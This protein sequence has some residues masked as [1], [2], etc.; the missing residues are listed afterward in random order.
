M[1]TSIPHRKI[2]PG[3]RSSERPNQLI[4]TSWI[5]MGMASPRTTKQQE[6]KMKIKP[7]KTN[8]ILAAFITVVAL[9]IT[10][11]TAYASGENLG[12]AYISSVTG[13]NGECAV[14]TPTGQGDKWD[15]QA[16]GTYT[17]TISGA[18]DCDLGQ[19][20]QI[21]VIVH[22][23]IGGNIY[24]LANYV[25]VGVYRFTIML[26]GQCQTMPIEYCTASGIGVP[27][28]QPGSGMF[29]QGYDGTGGDGHV[30]HLRTATFGANCAVT[31]EDN[32]CQPQATPT[33]TPCTASITA[34]KYYD[35][36]TD[37]KRNGT[38]LEQFL[39][40]P[41]C[42]TSLTD[43][44]F[45]PVQHSSSNGSCAT[46]SNLGPGTYVVT[47]GSATGYVGTTNSST[48]TI[49][50]CDQNVEVDFGNYCT[51]P[52]GGLTLGFWSNK[53]GNKILTGDTSGVGRNLLAA[54]VTLLNNPTGIGPVL[55]NA[56]GTIHTFDSNYTNFRS[57]LL[58]ANA[59]NMAYMLSAQLVALKLDVTYPVAPNLAVDGN[60]FDI[61][62]GMTVN[63]LI[64]MAGSLLHA[65]G[66]TLS[67]NT[68]RVGQESLKNCI[69]AIN[70]NGPVVPVAP[71][72]HSGATVSCGQ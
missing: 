49:D 48:I 35:F 27:A 64:T 7:N 12:S 53:N 44:S 57:W 6:S 54:V 72:D 24:T 38:P 66:Y 5:A 56:N 20:S 40:W 19:D 71:C 32:S 67:G 41:F 55:R 45:A 21:G 16:G 15:I 8:C 50:H 28:N 51:V 68:D 13:V 42:L 2:S 31:G 52:S 22:N 17:V 1:E 39:S 43:S 59:T 9:C 25:D 34:C 30:G 62:S 69:D 46:F 3:D 47:E 11:T 18:T 33:P 61:C 4:Q 37:G 26:N 10:M 63:Q 65:D 29:A 58:G 70:N 14:N 23:S 36:N 60:A